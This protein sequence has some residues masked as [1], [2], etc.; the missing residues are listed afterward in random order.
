M[1][2]ILVEKEP[3]PMKLDVLGVEDWELWEKEPSEFPWHYAQ[4]ETCYV[5][6]GEAVI[7]P[8]DGGEAVTIRAGDL[9]VFMS[10]L[11]CR[12]QVRSPLRKHYRVG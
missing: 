11:T 2:Q 12:W 3:S 6:E 10:G 8:D 1:A 9:V 4:T 5:L 7:T